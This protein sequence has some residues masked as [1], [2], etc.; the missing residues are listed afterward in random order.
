M[1]ILEST[2]LGLH[3]LFGER[4]ENQ[5]IFSCQSDRLT[6]ILDMISAE[7]AGENETQIYFSRASLIVKHCDQQYG[8]FERRVAGLAGCSR[9]YRASH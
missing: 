5:S 1:K 2:L 6:L 3:M 4:V 9:G 7:W 8:D